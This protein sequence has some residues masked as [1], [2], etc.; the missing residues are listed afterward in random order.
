MIFGTRNLV[1][2]DGNA[3][4][5]VAITIIR[6]T[7]EFEDTTSLPSLVIKQTNLITASLY[8]CSKKMCAFN[9]EKVVFFY[10]TLLCVSAETILSY[11]IELSS[12]LSESKDS[13]YITQRHA[14]IYG[15][16]L[17]IKKSM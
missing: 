10:E 14:D 15:S 9:V 8:V 7:C 12:Q 1:F 2:N 3:G 6:A 4:C 17:N 5:N 13:Y 11:T 16:K